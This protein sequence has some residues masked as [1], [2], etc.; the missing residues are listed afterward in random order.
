MRR[1]A[2][3]R[4][5]EVSRVQEFQHRKSE[6]HYIFRRKEKRKKTG[7]RKNTKNGEWISKQ[8]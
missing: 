1:S 4:K 2:Q 5:Q 6:A 7:K 3:Q 8:K